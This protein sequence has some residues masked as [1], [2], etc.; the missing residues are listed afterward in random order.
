M[1]EE[2]LESADPLEEENMEEIKPEDINLVGVEEITMA[3]REEITERVEEKT[4]TR[5]K[6]SLLFFGYLIL[7]ALMV[8]LFVVS[9]FLN[10]YTP[11]KLLTDFWTPKFLLFIGAGVLAQLIDGALGMAYGMSSSS[12]LVALG[13]PAHQASA[14]V[15]VAEIFTTGASGISHLHLKN[16]NKKL[17]RALIIPGVVGALAGAF[18]VSYFGKELGKAITPWISMYLLI[19]GVLIIRKALIKRKKKRKIGN[20]V[21]LAFTGGFMDSAGGGGWGPIVSSTLLGKGRNPIY[22]IGS[23][24]LAEFF[25]AAASASMFTIMQGLQSLPPILGLVIGGLMAAPFGAILV[26]KI[27]PKSL[28]VVV[29]IVVII[30]NTIMIYRGRDVIAGA[31]SA[32]F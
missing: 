29:G 28:M 20:V 15:H 19:L 11:E 9:Y 13:A 4:N 22:T 17:A 21:P 14:A 6:P 1:N 7:V 18:M 2:E 16:V 26:R 32:L 23:V 27:K 12:L 8:L 3:D 31:F 24:N 5:K 10:G 30:I 25:V